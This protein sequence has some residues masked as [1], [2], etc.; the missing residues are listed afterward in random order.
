MHRVSEPA[1]NGIHKYSLKI[2]QTFKNPRYEL[3]K[4]TPIIDFF[5]KIYVTNSVE[6]LYLVVHILNSQYHVTN[7]A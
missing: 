7:S 2:E 4:N 5:H 1:R 6:T 3:H